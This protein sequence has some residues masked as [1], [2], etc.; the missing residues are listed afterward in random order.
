MMRP[1]LSVD[2]QARST[3]YHFLAGLYLLEVD[4]AQLQA[5]KALE[6]PTITSEDADDQALAESYALLA[7]ALGQLT[8]EALDELAADYA[9]TFLAAGKAMGNAAHPYAGSYS[10][11]P[12]GTN[13]A[14]E[15]QRLYLARGLEPDPNS[16]RTMH[17]HVGLMLEYL[18]LLCSEQADAVN[19]GETE[20]ARQLRLEQGDFLREKLCPWVF[21]F[22]A[23]VKK[24][25]SLSFYPAVASLT[26]SFLRRENALFQN[27]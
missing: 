21:R 19:A 11:S 5:M 27:Q 2:H 14:W 12:T 23:D 13:T 22:T 4:A 20:K 26:E 9:G 16:Y 24:Y 8:A 25:A 1:E 15:M 10:D 6:F 7:A 17:D 18:S 3:M